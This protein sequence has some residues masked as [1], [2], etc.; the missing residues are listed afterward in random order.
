MNK[1]EHPDTGLD[2]I[3]SVP[4]WETLELSRLAIKR[5]QRKPIQWFKQKLSW[6]EPYFSEKRCENLDM[7]ATYCPYHFNGTE[8]G[9]YIYLSYFAA[10]L[11]N[12][13]ETTKLPIAQAHP[14]ALEC[15]QSHGAF[16]YLMECF[17]ERS[18]HARK[19]KNSELQYSYYR[20]YKR[21]KYCQF[22][23]TVECFEE[24]LANAYAF[25]NHPEWDDSKIIYLRQFY[26]RQREGYSQAAFLDEMSL[27]VLYYL[28][29]RQLGLQDVFCYSNALQ[30]WIKQNT[31]FRSETLPVFLVNDGLQDSELETVLELFFPSC[32]EFLDF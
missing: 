8:Y 10:F 1:F 9:L 3:Y 18:A 15:I 20:N 11:L 30:Q 32:I 28:L 5:L 31:P 14:F 7:I 6:T 26:Q 19:H 24:T 2:T 23:G 13:L 12:I 17:V 29:E 22:W 25:Q 27:S 4:D 16:H 21:D